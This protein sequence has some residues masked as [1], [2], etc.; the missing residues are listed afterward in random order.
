MT[1]GAEAVVASEALEPAAAELLYGSES[2][3]VSIL[4]RAV[5]QPQRWTRPQQHARA[6]C[7]RTTRPGRAQSWAA[8]WSHCGLE[9]LAAAAQERKG[10]QRASCDRCVHC[11][12][13]RRVEVPHSSP[14]R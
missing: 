9:A 13:E 4:V 1:D 7:G 5:Q 10:S 12:P 2:D 11:E 6:S 14:G 8:W 3:G